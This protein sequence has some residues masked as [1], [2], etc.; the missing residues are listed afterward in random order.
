MRGRK[1]PWWNLHG[2]G[3][4]KRSH[5]IMTYLLFVIPVQKYRCCPD[6]NNTTCKLR[7][8][9]NSFPTMADVFHTR[10]LHSFIR[11]CYPI[12]SLASGNVSVT[13]ISFWR[14][15]YSYLLVTHA[16]GT[17]CLGVTNAVAVLTLQLFW[18]SVSLATR[19]G[20]CSLCH[21]IIFIIMLRLLPPTA[22]A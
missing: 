11:S 6:G 22:G 10:A 9:A 13:A 3:V 21:L 12:H 7:R 15:P 1:T 14:V 2:E 16:H 18:A 20:I 5:P 8:L 19:H 17:L 4:Q